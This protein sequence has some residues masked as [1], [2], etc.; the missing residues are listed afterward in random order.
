MIRQRT[1]S[2][3]EK[4]P[5]ATVV[6]RLLCVLLC[7][8]M[9]L[10]GALS[11][12]AEENALSAATLR[13]DI[14]LFRQYAVQ[15]SEQNRMDSYA[16]GGFTWDTERRETSWRYYNGFMIDAILRLGGEEAFRFAEA[17]YRD[18]ILDDGS[19]PDYLHGYLDSVEPARPLLRLIR[20]CGPEE[21]DR[22]LKAV[23]WVYSRLEEQ[24]TYPVCGNNF[25][26]HQ[27]ENGKPAESS[28][29]Y[30]IFLDGLYM[31]QPFLAECAAAVRE[32]I[33]FLTDRKGRPVSAEKLEEDIV[34]RYVWLHAYLYDSGKKMYQHGWNLSS[35][36]GNGHYWGRGIGWLAMSMAD[37]AGILP[38]GGGRDRVRGLLL[39]LLDGM[40][41]YQDTGTGM[42]NNV[43][44]REEDLEGNRPE[45]SVTA[46]L[47]YS[48]LKVW[49]DGYA[50]G[51]HYPAAGL[52]AFH[53]V[54]ETKT[55]VYDGTI[56]VRDTYLKSGVGETDEYY[57]KEPYT[58]DEAK[59]TAAL[60]MAA[61]EA[62]QA[63]LTF[64]G[65]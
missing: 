62:E 29:Q 31:T 16:R 17:F 44:D 61:S 51:E 20:V 9:I 57:C 19:I 47:A 25:L 26:H 2:I 54:A 49:N 1:I 39:E 23:Q 13:S 15:L 27:E 14:Q 10:T 28:R 5:A 60:L 48:L 56:S 36:R 32:G 6:R 53:G 40:L 41:L 4:C 33:L 42:W 38:E 11:E 45:T 22:Y 63:I 52:R 30:P 7:I 58:T 59:G 46:M 37:V 50:P 21:R 64:S 65:E 12:P 3:S 8:G 55:D 18:N 34:S 35:A 43:P 24:R